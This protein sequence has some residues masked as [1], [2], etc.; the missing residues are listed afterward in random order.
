MNL[1]SKRIAAV[2]L[3]S[4]FVFPVVVASKTQGTVLGVQES[5]EASNSQ[6]IASGAREVL[7]PQTKNRTVVGKALWDSRQ[8]VPV[9]SNKFAP[10]SIIEVK[11]KDQVKTFLVEGQRND[12]AEETVLILSTEGFLQLGVDPEKQDIIDVEVSLANNS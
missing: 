6:N 2:L 10:G 7:T 3:T 12:L 9:S 11:Y 4:V 1:L 5:L 8:T